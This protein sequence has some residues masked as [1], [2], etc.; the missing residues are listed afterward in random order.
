L[1]EKLASGRWT[2]VVESFNSYRLG[3]L[4][5]RKAY[6]VQRKARMDSAWMS[7]NENHFCPIFL[8]WQKNTLKENN[9][10]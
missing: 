7:W 6:P 10:I 4:P 9:I 1:C 8:D 5:K 2:S 3:F